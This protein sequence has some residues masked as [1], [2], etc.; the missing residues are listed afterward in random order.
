[1]QPTNLPARSRGVL[2][3]SVDRQT[4][5][6]LE[7]IAAGSAIELYAISA[8]RCIEIA[9]VETIAQVAEVGLMATAHISTVELLLVQQAPHA[10]ARLRHVAD[11]AAAAIAGQVFKTARSL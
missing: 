11:G 10:E 9:K 3:S 8:Q 7:R 2:A 6:A 5:R 4:D 1:M